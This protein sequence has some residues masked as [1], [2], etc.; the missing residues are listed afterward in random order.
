MKRATGTIPAPESAICKDK[1]VDFVLLEWSRDLAVSQPV[2]IRHF[3]LG[4]LDARV[5]EH[6][7][8]PR[9]A[10][11]GIRGPAGCRNRRRTGQAAA[12]KM[13]RHHRDPRTR[14]RLLLG[15]RSRPADGA[16]L[17]P[18]FR[19]RK[20]LSARLRQVDRAVGAGAG[21]FPVNSTGASQAW[22]ATRFS[23]TSS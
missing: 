1:T 23:T 17:P 7:Q 3:V 16:E 13:V 15:E 6:A 2:R 5:G 20:W 19:Q 11:D 8:E 4:I 22:R 9:S 18:N 14:R 21:R 10:P 12:A